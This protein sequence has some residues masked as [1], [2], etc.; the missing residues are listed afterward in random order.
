[1]NLLII[2]DK[3]D[4]KTYQTIVKAVPNV[5]VLGTVTKISA[6]FI[7]ELKNRY[8]PHA[9][10]I[11]TAVSAKD[12]AVSVAIEHIAQAYPYMKLLVLAEETDNHYYPSYCTVKGRVSSLELKEILSNM[13]KGADYNG[14]TAERKSIPDIDGSAPTEDLKN[15]PPNVFQSKVDKLSTLKSSKIKQPFRLRMNPIIA[16]AIV[17]A[18]AIIVIIGAVILKNINSSAAE[19][20]TADEATAVE[21]TVAMKT[22]PENLYSEAEQLFSSAL[23]VTTA[24]STMQAPTT[25]PMYKAQATEAPQSN[26]SEKS[27]ESPKESSDKES[28]NRSAVSNNR[29]DSESRDSSGGS[30][31]QQESYIGGEPVVSYHDGSYYNAKNNE[32]SSVKLSYSSKSMSVGDTLQLS[33]TVSPST[34]NQS[35]SW[36]TSNPSVVSVSNGYLV[37]RRSGSATI[38]AR[39][40]NG[41]SASCEV[42]VTENNNSA[43][44]H[45]SAAEYNVSTGQTVTITLYG[46]NQVTWDMSNNSPYIVSHSGNQLTLRARTAGTTKITAKDNSTGKTYTCTFNVK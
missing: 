4:V 35:L 27:E 32:V 37:A 34:A 20:A 36:S 25:Q 13:A 1:M 10:V 40:E 38:T 16:A 46:A 8:N 17:G 41:K 24:P 18:A 31:Q 19:A 11:D 5:S 45:L 2:A 29:S 3:S 22:E 15:I 6:D 9:I 30:N 39:A 7:A 14:N 42:R 26:R 12:I 23:T 28:E 43:D 21:T 33:A 44:V